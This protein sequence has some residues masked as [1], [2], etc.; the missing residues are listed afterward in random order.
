M[1]TVSYVH[2]S[3]RVYPCVESWPSDDF[4]MLFLSVRLALESDVRSTGSDCVMG[5]SG[6]VPG[7]D[8]A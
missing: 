2:Y 1:A 3:T 6:G 7:V 4:N 5:C 8:F